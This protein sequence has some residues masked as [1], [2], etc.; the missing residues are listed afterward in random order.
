MNVFQVSTFKLATTIVTIF[1]TDKHS[2]LNNINTALVP[3]TI[4]NICTVIPY[5]VK[6]VP[7]TKT[8][9]QREGKYFEFFSLHSLL[10]NLGVIAI[11]SD[12]FNKPNVYLISTSE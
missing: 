1:N 12:N 9:I 8:L 4:G 5:T 2:A 11:F 7:I 3:F 10:F 6:L